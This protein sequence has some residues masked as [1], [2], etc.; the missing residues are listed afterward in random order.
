VV[1]RKRTW[2]ANQ[3]C[4]EWGSPSMWSSVSVV[5]RE[6]SRSLETEAAVADECCQ[7][8]LLSPCRAQRTGPTSRRR[9]T[10]NGGEAGAP[11]DRWRCRGCWIRTG[12]SRRWG[13]SQDER[14][15]KVRNR[16][17]AATDL[18]HSTNMEGI[19]LTM[20]GDLA[21]HGRPPS[22]VRESRLEGG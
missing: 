20:S 21:Y 3:L 16:A 8:L 7:C 11:E 19:S 18:T 15:H 10:T 5:A 4:S 22:V 9:V 13:R 6:V 2:G 17:M 12:R 14:D 1:V